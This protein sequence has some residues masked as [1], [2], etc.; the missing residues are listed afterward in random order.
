MS[1]LSQAMPAPAKAAAPRAT[2]SP[3]R[4][5]EAAVWLPWAVAMAQVMA[6]VSVVGCVVFLGLGEFFFP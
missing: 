6:P 3:V 1:Q 4:A 5:L 2:R